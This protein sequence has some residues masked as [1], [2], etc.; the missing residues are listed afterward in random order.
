MCGIAWILWQFVLGMAGGLLY[1]CWRIEWK[2][3]KQESLRSDSDSDS[4][5]DG[6]DDNGHEITKAV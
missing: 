2:W 3:A 5:S 4:D 1:K 6:N